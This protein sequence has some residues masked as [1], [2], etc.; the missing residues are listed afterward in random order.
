[1]EP[2]KK[3]RRKKMNKNYY[4]VYAW[5]ETHKGFI[6]PVEYSKHSTEEEARDMFNSVKCDNPYEKDTNVF[7][8]YCVM[9]YV[10]IDESEEIID[11]VEIEKFFY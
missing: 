7:E 11:C 10:T 9:E 2:G 5:G 1:M 4:T 3:E 6:D 8:P